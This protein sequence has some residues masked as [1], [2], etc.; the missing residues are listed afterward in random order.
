MIQSLAM[1]EEVENHQEEEN[2][3]EVKMAPEVKDL[4]RRV[5]VVTNHGPLVVDHQGKDLGGRITNIRQILLLGKSLGRRGRI[6]L[7]IH[8]LV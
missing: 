3:Q 4:G 6:I 2:H 5:V 1:E 7:T 8:Y